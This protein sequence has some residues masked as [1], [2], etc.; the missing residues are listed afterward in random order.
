LIVSLATPS[1]FIYDSYSKKNIKD[2]AIME[3]GKIKIALKRLKV[4]PYLVETLPSII[5]YSAQKYNVNWKDIVATIQVE[6]GFREHAV[7]DSIPGKTTLRARGFGQHLPSTGEWIAERTGLP[8]YGPETL[9]NP[10]FSIPATAYYIAEEYIIWQSQEKMV[11][12]YYLGD[13]R[14]HSYYDGDSDARAFYKEHDAEGHWQKYKHY[15]E[16]INDI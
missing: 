16:M 1:F 6:S 7:G 9:D 5:S 14:L 12:G 13:R 10:L 2:D 11:K 3:E 4:K 8:W 15:Y